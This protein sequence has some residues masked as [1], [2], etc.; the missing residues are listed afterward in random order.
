M[1][2]KTEA[3]DNVNFKIKTN[4]VVPINNN[5]DEEGELCKE[6]IKK[7]EHIAE[8]THHRNPNTDHTGLENNV[9]FNP[10]EDRMKHY[11]ELD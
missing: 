3:D 4:N 10:E 5:D 11:N 2:L 6:D 7:L 8:I 1:P 9:Q